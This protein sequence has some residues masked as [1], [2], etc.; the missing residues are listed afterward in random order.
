MVG[1]DR[2]TYAN[3]TGARILVSVHMNASS[4]PTMDYTTTLFG[5][6]RKDKELAY[7]VFNGLSALPAADGTGSIATRSPYS[8]ASGVLLKS[9]MPATI[10]ETVFITSDSEG[11]LLSDSTGARQQQIAQALRTGIENYLSTH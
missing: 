8:Y 7:A 2:Y 1:S 11:R 10:V 3:T 9:N 6:W 5:K 4:D